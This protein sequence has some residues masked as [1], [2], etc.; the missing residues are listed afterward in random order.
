MIV[1]LLATVA[2]AW[3]LVF[4]VSATAHAMVAGDECSVYKHIIENSSQKLVQVVPD[5]Q[6]ANW[7]FALRCLVP[8]VGELKKEIGS[9][10]ISP[11]VLSKYLSVTGA[12]RAIM[13]RLSVTDTKQTAPPGS[14]GDTLTAFI[15]EFRRLDNIDV[16]SVLTYGARSESY[17]ARVNSVLILGNVIDNS[18]VCVPLMQIYDKRTQN[19]KYYVNGRANLLGV[20]SV[21]AP[22]AYAENYASIDSTREYVLQQI[23]GESNVTTTMQ[24]LENIRKRLLSQTNDSNKG[25]PL[26]AAWKRNCKGYMSSFPSNPEMTRRLQY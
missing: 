21:V 15:N 16:I 25:V 1:R 2:S 22:W 20:I 11:D 4:S 26:D 13:T 12:I 14:A 8:I 5:Q 9:P 6:L 3:F 19:E 17:D 10:Q 24:I 7:P 18:T 23:K